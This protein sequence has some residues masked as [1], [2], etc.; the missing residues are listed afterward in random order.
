MIYNLFISHSWAYSDAYN[1]G[2]D[3]GEGIGNKASEMFGGYD[4]ANLAENVAATAA[5]TGDIKDSMDTSTEELKYLHDIA[6]RDAI[7]RFTTAEIKVEMTNNNNVSSSMDLD[8][9]VDYLVL[10]VNE[11]MATAADGVHV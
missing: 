9:M 5:N 3:W 4:G 1:S 8:G 11:A 6:E 7:N 2:Y 10:G